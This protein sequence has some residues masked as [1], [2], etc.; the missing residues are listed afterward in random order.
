MNCLIGVS[1][2]LLAYQ[3]G[4]GYYVYAITQVFLVLSL[5]FAIVNDRRKINVGYG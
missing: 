3:H 4:C 5:V 2:V 1:G